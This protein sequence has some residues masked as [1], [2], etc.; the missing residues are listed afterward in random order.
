ME[1]AIRWVPSQSLV[2]A[3]QRTSVAFSTEHPVVFFSADPSSQPCR[4]HQQLLLLRQ[5]IGITLIGLLGRMLLLISHPQ[6]EMLLHY[7]GTRTV[8]ASTL[9]MPQTQ[10]HSSTCVR[11][12]NRFCGL[13][14]CIHVSG[15]RPCTITQNHQIIRKDSKR[16]KKRSCGHASTHTQ[17]EPTHTHT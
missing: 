2:S 16:G 10:L 6:K 14:L 17:C 7:P 1:S 8:C 11:G 3:A 9:H 13:S 4:G 15:T 5:S 12:P